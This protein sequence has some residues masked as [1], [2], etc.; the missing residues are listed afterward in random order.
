M[1]VG[2]GDVQEIATG[3]Q[4]WVR[5][6]VDVQLLVEPAAVRHVVG[7]AAGLLQD[8]RLGAFGPR[9]EVIT[10]RHRP[11]ETPSGASLVPLTG[12]RP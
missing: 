4:R 9:D 7:V 5:A 12:G 1:V 2:A 10:R 6:T 11:E 8:G 3:L